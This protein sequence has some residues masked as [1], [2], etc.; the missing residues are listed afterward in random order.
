M[1]TRTSLPQRLK[2][3]RTRADALIVYLFVCLGDADGF[4]VVFVCLFVLVSLFV[5]VVVLWVLFVV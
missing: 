4:V 3:L 1:L 2:P 5:F